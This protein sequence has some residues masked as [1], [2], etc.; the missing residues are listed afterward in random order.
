[1]R[2]SAL[3]R[4][5]VCTLLLTCLGLGGFATTASAAKLRPVSGLRAIEVGT[6]SITLRWKDRSRGES[7]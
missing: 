7:S 6:E 1:M 2:P 5:L 4:S 3:R